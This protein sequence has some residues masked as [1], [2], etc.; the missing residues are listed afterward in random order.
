M[1]ADL[2]LVDGD[3]TRDI[4]ATRAIVTI[5]KNGHALDRAPVSA[6]TGEVSAAPAATLISQFDGASIDVATGG[7][8]RDTSD[9]MRGGSSHAQH[10]LVEGGADGSRGALEISGEIKPGFAFPWAGAMFFVAP[11]PMEP[12]D[13]AARRELVFH[14]RGDGRALRV[15]L[16]SG[17][18]AQAMPSM[19]EFVAGS[20]WREYR[21]PL[22]D[23]SGADPAL[24]RAVAFCAG[25]PAGAFRFRID[26]VELR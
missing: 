12:V 20:E 22:A 11:V 24:L 14:A 17:P 13:Y 16:F 25:E 15:M 26:R 19:L 5:W 23:F 1:R 3:P 7:S 21:M 18:S 6:P 10:R 9:A 8:W 4:T 2:V